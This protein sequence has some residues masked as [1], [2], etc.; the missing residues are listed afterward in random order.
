MSRWLVGLLLLANLVFFANMRWG[1]LLAADVDSVAGQADINPD[2]IKLLSEVK[3]ATTLA[4]ATS[5]VQPGMISAV[6][7]FAPA[8]MLTSEL[9]TLVKAPKQCIEWGEFS[10]SGLAQV[11]SS[12]AAMQLGEK[13]TQRT[14]EHTSGFWV[15]IPPLKNHA[16][17]QRKIGQL[18]KMGVSDYFVVQ[19]DGA[20]LNAISLGVFRTEESAQKFL[21]SLHLKGVRSAKIGERMSKLKFTIFVLTGLDAT[22]ED[23][24]RLIQKDFPESE[25]KMADCN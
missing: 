15:F 4:L 20:W 19:E 12:V 2:K 11:Q 7:A 21:G 8:S 25:L 14:I 22:A 10:G 9:T 24:V 1:A 17:V 13:V 3:S 16:E 6:T 23:K 18:K 5:A